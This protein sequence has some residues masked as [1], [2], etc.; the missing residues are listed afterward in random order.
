MSLLLIYFDSGRAVVC[1][2]DRAVRFDEAGQ[3]E[4][5]EERVPKFCRAGRF[6]IGATGDSRRRVH[7]RASPLLA[8]DKSIRFP[9]RLNSHPINRNNLIPA[10]LLSR[11][12]QR[13]GFYLCYPELHGTPAANYY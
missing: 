5:M 2:D 8:L 3:T 12:T 11:P 7:I 1:S 13:R 6:L 10:I 4:P 9:I